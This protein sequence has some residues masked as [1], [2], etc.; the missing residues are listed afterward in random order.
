[1]MTADKSINRRR[2]LRKS[3]AVVSAAVAA[4]YMIPSGVLASPGPNERIGI[5]AIGVGRQGTDMMNIV[6]G[7]KDARIV[8]AADAYLPRAQEFGAKMNA[9]AYQDY[10]KLLERKDV[11]AVLTALPERWHALAAIH[12]CQAGKDVYGE[13]PLSFTIREGRLMVEAAR[14]YKRVFQTGSHWRSS[15]P[16]G[17]GCELIRS[18]RIGKIERVVAHNYPSPWICGLPAQSVPQ[19]LDWDLWCGPAEVLPYNIDLFAP[20]AKPGWM[21]FNTYSNGEMSGWGAHGLDQVQCALGM[22]ASGPIEVWTEGAKFDPPAYAKPEARKRGDAICGQPKVFFRYA[23]GTVMELGDGPG[24]GGVFHG[25]KGTITI[26]IAKYAIEPANLVTET[27][28]PIRLAYVRHNH[29]QNWL[30][31]IKSREKPVA[32]VEIGHRSATVCHLGNI[33][34]WT[35]GT[36]RKLRW[37]PVKEIFPDDAEANTY[38]DRQYRKPYELPERV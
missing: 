19:G 5:G 31:C 15:P 10:H 35:G 3:A 28:K 37:D 11:S 36:G 8:A 23:G 30:D 22:D 33:A 6:A 26:D 9:V 18:G 20:R 7:C 24:G 29:V 4:P 27:V 38:L 25:E 12:A 14:K 32:D 1:M 13:K 17:F 34:R 21:S 16:N 2:F